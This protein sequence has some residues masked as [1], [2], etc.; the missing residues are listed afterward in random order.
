MLPF[1]GRPPALTAHQWHLL[2]VVGAATLFAEYGMAILGLALPQIQAGLRVAEGEVG[3]LTAII[4]LGVIPALLLTAL[5]D[6]VGRR[7]LLLTT[8]VGFT[9]V[10]LLTAFAQ[11]AVQFTALQFVSRVFIAAEVMLAVVVVAE[12]FDADTRGWGIGMIGALGTLGHGVAAILFSLVNVLPFGWRALYVIGVAPVLLLPWFR[13][14]LVETRRFELHRGTQ[15]GDFGWHAALRPFRNLGRMYP[16]RMIALGAALIPLAFTL[17]TAVTFLSKSLQQAHG[18]SPASV[19]SL[20]LTIGVLAPIGNVVGGALADRIGRKRVIVV[21]VLVNSLAVALFYNTRGVWVPPLMGVM[22]LTLAM[23]LVMF[24]A[25][26]SELFPTSY[27]STASGVRALVTT[28]GAALGLWME[29]LLYGVT[30]SH[31]RAITW[32]LVITPVAPLVVAF[33][34]PETANQE[35]EDIAPE[36]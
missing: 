23:I 31:A 2:G 15:A 33:F 27:R 6:H 28:L 20:F 22:L 17:E 4:R 1:L 10:T 18:Y 3:T 24:A 11:D 14:S 9:L 12:E 29:S 19:A 8:I 32:M 30:G 25:L 7:V 13:R 16:G 26:G 21:S 5:A 36:K 35:L 34:L